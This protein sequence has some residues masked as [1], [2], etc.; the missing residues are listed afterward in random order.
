MQIISIISKEAGFPFTTKSPF[1]PSYKEALFLEM[2]YINKKIIVS[3]IYYSPS[4]KF[5]ARSSSWWPKD[6]NTTGELS[7]YS[8]RSTNGFDQLINE[9]KHIQTKSS[10]C[11]YLLFTD[12]PNLTVNFEVHSSLHPNCHHEMVH[13]S[14]NLNASQ[15]PPIISSTNMGLR[16]AYLTIIRKAVELVNWLLTWSDRYWCTSFHI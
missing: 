7:L 10:Y 16:K 3:V 11:I 12:Q 4:Q 2:S 14:F 9:P 8:L 13:S 6:I 15:P 1:L 5:N